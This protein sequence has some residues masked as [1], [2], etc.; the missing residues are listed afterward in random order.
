MITPF[1][2]PVELQTGGVL[3]LD[4]TEGPGPNYTLLFTYTRD[5]D[6]QRFERS[7]VMQPPA[8]LRPSWQSFDATASTRFVAQL[9]QLATQVRNG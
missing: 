9:N 1:D 3:E 5:S 7:V 4:I 8:V 2:I 6:G